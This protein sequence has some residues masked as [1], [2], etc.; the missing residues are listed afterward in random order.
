[1]SY[2]E[3]SCAMCTRDTTPLGGGLTKGSILVNMSI[4]VDVIT[5]NVKCP[6]KPW[7]LVTFNPSWVFRM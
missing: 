4:R 6:V 7:T 1:V 3:H 5:F 2:Q